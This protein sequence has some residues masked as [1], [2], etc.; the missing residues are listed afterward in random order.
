MQLPKVVLS[1]LSAILGIATAVSGV[2]AGVFTD[3]TATP[4]LVMKILGGLTIV[5]TVIR[6]I[7]KDFGGSSD[8]IVQAAAAA[9]QQAGAVA[10]QKI[11]AS[12]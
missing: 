7:M 9:G 1:W 11:A 12:Q 6:G 2:M 4:P 8:P 5:A 3:P 10:G